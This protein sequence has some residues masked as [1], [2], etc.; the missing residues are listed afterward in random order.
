MSNRTATRR[1]LMTTLA[2]GLW[3]AASFFVFGQ[4][5]EKQVSEQEQKPQTT[6]KVDTAL[7][8]VEAIVTDR[9]GRFVTGLNRGDFLVREDGAPQEI[10]NF[11]ST[12]TPFNVALLLDTSHSTH[13]KLGIIRKAAL[14]FIKQL[15]PQDRVMIVSFDDKVRFLG[16]FSNDHKELERQIRSVESSF[17]TSLYDAISRTI[18]E[19]LLPLQGRRAIVVLTDGVDTGSSQATFDST[20][21][22]IARTGV[23]TYAVQYDTRNDGGPVMKPL[24]VPTIKQQSFLAPASYLW[25]G[26][27]QSQ[28]PPP[29]NPPPE[30]EPPIQ[31]PSSMRTTIGPPPP[32]NLPPATASQQVR[33]Q[34][35][36]P[37]RDPYVT[38][39]NF[40]RTVAIQSGAR[41]IRAE[42]IENTAQAFGII[43]DEL[44]HQYT[45]AYYSTNEKRDGKYR[46]IEVGL[47]RN[48]LTVRARHGYLA[49]KA[50]P[51]E[52]ESKES[53][54]KLSDIKR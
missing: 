9:M 42:I 23:I 30:K 27:S 49:P 10:S 46:Q 35:S 40:L 29:Q 43:S 18:T 51:T 6:I 8:T 39:S 5:Q 47:K 31:L 28:P 17:K 20:L 41:Y 54:K 15:L 13:N 25:Q 37:I 48:D 36:P 12:E 21:D 11:S 44:R 52:S 38:A 2:T 34:S 3:L 26:Q 22:L 16:D 14:T 7:V 33:G 45:L 50:E 4:G 19:K 32:S 24:S 53:E 1:R